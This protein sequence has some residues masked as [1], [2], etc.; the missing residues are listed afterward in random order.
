VPVGQAGV[1]VEPCPD[2]PAARVLGVIPPSRA[3]NE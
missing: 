1:A 3:F 2:G